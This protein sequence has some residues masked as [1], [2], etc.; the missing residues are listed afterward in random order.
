MKNHVQ[1]GEVLTLAAPYDVLS[2]GGLKV[3]SIFAVAS[4]DALT[5][6][7]VEGVTCGVFDLPK[8]SAQ[9]WTQGQKVYWD[10]TAKLATSTASG[11]SLIGV[12]TE[13]AAN[14]SAIGRVRL[15]GTSL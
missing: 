8:A 9:A 14:P 5:G 1:K 6:A 2:G 15:D 12:A 10:D 3:G 13:P 11:N 4:G 7:A